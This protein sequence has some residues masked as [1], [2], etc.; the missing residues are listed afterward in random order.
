MAGSDNPLSNSLELHFGFRT[1]KHVK[2]TLMGVHIIE[3]DEDAT[4]E[5]ESV[6]MDGPDRLLHVAQLLRDRRESAVDLAALIAELEAQ[7]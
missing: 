7:G 5:L 4:E 1:Q 6:I 3:G 2:L